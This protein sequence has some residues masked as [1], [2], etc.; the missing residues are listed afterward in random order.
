MQV[1]TLHQNNI[2]YLEFNIISLKQ[3]SRW[4]QPIFFSKV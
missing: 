4:Y 1:M 2:A 3:I